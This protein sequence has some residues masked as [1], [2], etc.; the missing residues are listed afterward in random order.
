[1]KREIISGILLTILLASVLTLSFGLQP[2]G[3]ASLPEIYMVPATND[4]DLTTT[5]C[6]RWNITFWVKD[7]P[8]PGVVG[9][10]FKCWFN[11]SWL[12]V[13]R[14]FRIR[15]DP[16]WIFWDP[17][18]VGGDMPTPVIDN[19]QGFVLAGGAVLL[20]T[21]VFGAGPF[22]LGIV[23]FHVKAGPAPFE[24]LFS[25]LHINNTETLLLNENLDA[26]PVI[27][28]D[29][30]VRYTH[31]I[32]WDITGHIMWTPDDK[33][34]IRDTALIALFYG[35]VEGDGNYDPRAD[36]SGP[37]FLVPDGK[38]DLRDVALVALHFGETYS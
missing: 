15:W 19:T 29:G 32:P 11:S 37:E 21:P 33:C 20:L 22:K 8:E 17:Y 26:I 34:D 3:A 35:S 25:D 10:Q 14:A 31:T 2:V 1:M 24:T 16:A 38:I 36:I 13:T 30:Y 27:K 4:F 5:P 23:E 6:H 18:G 28:T 7:V 9:Y 12:E